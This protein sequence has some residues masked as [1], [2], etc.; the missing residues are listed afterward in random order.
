MF[1]EVA[2]GHGLPHDPFKAIVAPRPIGWITTMSLDGDVNLSPYSFFNIVADSPHLVSFS[3]M[4]KKDA[5]TFAE[6]GGDFVCNFA[7]WDLRDQMNQSSAPFARGVN[8]MAKAGLTPVPSNLV[9][10]PRIAGVH[11]AL[12]CKWVETINL[13]NIDRQDAGY[14]MVI[15]QVV[16]VHIEDRFLS[17]G[18]VD[19]AAMYPIM[20][21][22]YFDYF[23]VGP[24]NKFSMPR[25]SA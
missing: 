19:T 6:E 8:E 24:E 1:Y 10:P 14:F 12:E 18:I 2:R 3:S 13:K 25:P 4:G 17:D 15:G 5:M 23:T 22:G 9:R 16:G 20:R 11:A 7:T 21:G